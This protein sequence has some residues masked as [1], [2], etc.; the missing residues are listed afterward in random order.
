MRIVLILLILVVIFLVAIL[1]IFPYSSGEMPTVQSAN[2]LSE[3]A[4]VTTDDG[5]L[6]VM[7]ISENID[8]PVLIV[9]GGG[10][11][12]PQYLLEDM[13][14]SRLAENFTVCY[15]DYRGTGLNYRENIDPSD[16]T[17]ERYIADTGFVTD[18][19]TE[20]FQQ[21]PTHRI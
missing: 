11:G 15:W 3:R 21:K 2:G 8:N 20:R 13:Y 12:I 16:M 9:C 5:E 14:P 18:Y 7:L 1:I 10:P 17:T 4:V 19:L 6:A